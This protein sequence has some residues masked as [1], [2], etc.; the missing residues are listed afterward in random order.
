MGGARDVI[1]DFSSAQGD[2]IDLST[3]DAS[4]LAS[5]NQAFTFIGAGYFSF[6]VPGMVR[7]DGGV[8]QG[9]VN[10]DGIADFE[11]AL[12]GVTS[13]TAGDFIL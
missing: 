11:I 6:N 7:F 13:L 5:G 1:S 9:D 8:V 4:T 10:G 12:A 3:L 2:K